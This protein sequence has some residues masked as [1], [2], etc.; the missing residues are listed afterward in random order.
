MKRTVD[1]KRDLLRAFILENRLKAGPWAK[2]SGVSANSLYNFLNGHSNALDPITYAKLAR[3]A[4]V[5]VW[6][7]DGEPREPPSPTSVWVVGHVEAGAFREAVEWDRSLWYPVDVPIPTKF[8]G[9]AKAL[10]TRGPSMNQRYPEGTVVIWVD[11]LEF[12]PPRDGDRVVVYAI[13]KDDEV[14]ATVKKFT[15]ANGKKWLW[16][17]SD[18]PLFQAPIEIE[19]PGDRIKSIEIKGIVIGSYIPEAI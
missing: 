10:E 18:D 6:R 11:M 3:T 5:S 13:C 7:L 15:V 2:A 9:R 14:E 19:H 16:P 8:R 4:G 12:R 17:E 1:E